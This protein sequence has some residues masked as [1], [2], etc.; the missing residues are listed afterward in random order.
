MLTSLPLSSRTIYFLFIQYKADHL[1]LQRRSRGV[2]QQR[3]LPARKFVSLIVIVVCL[4]LL[5]IPRLPHM[6]A[7]IDGELAFVVV[8]ISHLL[9]TIPRKERACARNR[10]MNVCA[11]EG[12]RGVAQWHHGVTYLRGAPSRRRGGLRPWRNASRERRSVRPRTRR[13]FLAH[14]RVVRSV[15]GV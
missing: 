14:R 5:R 1:P 15:L 12:R 4:E 2:V 3:K 10:K 8:C 13:P 9:R 11:A 7:M 6:L